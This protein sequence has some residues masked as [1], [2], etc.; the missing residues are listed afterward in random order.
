VVAVPKHPPPK[1]ESAP[2][3]GPGRRTQESNDSATVG[4]SAKDLK[5]FSWD[6]EGDGR[7]DVLLQV[8]RNEP[9][10][11]NAVVRFPDVPILTLRVVFEA[12]R[13]RLCVTRSGEYQLYSPFG[14]Y[15]IFAVLEEACERIA[16]GLNV[17]HE[18]RRWPNA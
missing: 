16:P 11:K 10:T 17:C 3:V 1:K 6:S 5:G 13:H 12:G 4:A 9:A 14:T 7:Q 18:G 15:E 2:G 8:G